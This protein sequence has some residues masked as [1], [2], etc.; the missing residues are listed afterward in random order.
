VDST[1]VKAVESTDEGRTWGTAMTI[2]SGASPAVWV[3]ATGLRFFAWVDGSAI[4]LRVRHASG[5]AIATATIV[6]S[7]AASSG[8]GGCEGEATGEQVLSYVT[9]G[10]AVETLKSTDGGVT[11]A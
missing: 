10:G 7:G 4:K 6:A 9:T 11:W 3:G 1:N 8:L 5:D 2:G